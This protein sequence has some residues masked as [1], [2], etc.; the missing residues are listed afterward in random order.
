MGTTYLNGVLTANTSGR[1]H[2]KMFVY[3]EGLSP[4]GVLGWTFTPATNRV[5]SAVE[6]VGIYRTALGN[7]G[8]L[9]IFGRP[10]SVTYPCPDGDTSNGW[11]PSKDFSELVCNITQIV[12]GGGHAQKIVHYA[13]H[14]DRLDTADP[15]LWRNA[16]YI[17]N[18]CADEWDLIWDHSYRER[19]RDCSVEG[20]YWWGPGIELSGDPFPRPQIMELGYEDTLLFHDGVWS[21]LPPNETGF[22]IPENRPDLSP[23][24]T[25]HLD[26]NGSFGVGNFV[27]DNDPPVIEGQEPLA[28]F[29]DGSIEL[30]TEVVQISD[31]DIDPAYHVAFDLTLYGG[32]N[33][34]RDEVTI[35]PDPDYF[36]PLNVP[37]SVSDGAVD[38]G[39]FEL[40]IDVTPV[41]DPPVVTGQGSLE[42]VERTPIT[43]RVEDVNIV[44]PDN[45]VPQLTI[46]VQDGAGYQHDGNIVTP[47]PGVIGDLLVTIVAADGELESAASE[48]VVLVTPDVTPPELMLLGTAT[49][50]AFV[51]SSY[52]DAG[53]VAVDAVDGDITDQIVTANTVDTSQVGTYTVSYTV[54]DLAGNEAASATRIVTVQVRTTPSR[55]GGGGC[56]IATAA[57]G[58]YLHDHVEALRNFRD[59]QLMTRSWGH[60][61]V[62]FYY[63]HSPPIAKAIEE[64]NALRLITR[65]MLTPVVYG[66][67]YPRTAVALLL[68][69]LVLLIGGLWRSRGDSSFIASMLIGV[70]LRLLR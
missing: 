51:G 61:L 10:C 34:S 13:N 44:D 25:F 22:R 31:R 54:S 65:W 38:S 35:T 9:S 11:Q 42:T 3:P 33:Y 16:V 21:Q 12:D 70:V 28:T 14:S 56:F 36:G 46:A 60:W 24:Q 1:L 32:D 7:S 67:L 23:W 18:Y 48:L 52:E 8:V 4:S 37:I 66:V 43:I 62:Q 17:W 19:K 15:P 27:N 50:T 5:D 59:R 45:D 6:V 2:T 55:S 30:T 40:L 63:Q 64:D 53:A 68:A 29:E 41:N 26:P 47:E 57:Y 49:V 39:V 58:S 20:C 69:S